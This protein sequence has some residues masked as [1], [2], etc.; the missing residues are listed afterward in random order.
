MERVSNLLLVAREAEA[1]CE[2]VQPC[3]KKVRVQL[4][5]E[6]LVLRY[7]T[8][9]TEVRQSIAYISTNI[10]DYHCVDEIVSLGTLWHRCIEIKN[11]YARRIT[12][13]KSTWGRPE[14]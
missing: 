6:E 8:Y 1:F 13:V 10:G 12:S 2:K 4:S 3:C 9:F 7:V 11:V 5:T 14:L